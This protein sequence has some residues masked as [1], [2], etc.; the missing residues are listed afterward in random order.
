MT[1]GQISAFLL[2]AR[3]Q[4][5]LFSLPLG[6]RRHVHRLG[7]EAVAAGTG[8]AQELAA[9]LAVHDTMKWASV[10]NLPP[11]RPPQAGTSPHPRRSL[12]VRRTAAD[13]ESCHGW[14]STES[15]AD[16]GIPIVAPDPYQEQALYIS[17]APTLGSQRRPREGG[18]SGVA[19]PTSRRRGAW[20]PGPSATSAVPDVVIPPSGAVLAFAS[21][22]VPPAVAAVPP[23]TP[24]GSH[25]ST[26]AGGRSRPWSEGAEAYILGTLGM[27]P[28][29]RWADVPHL[30]GLAG[31]VRLVAEV[32][33]VVDPALEAVRSVRITL[34]EFHSRVAEVHDIDRMSERWAAAIAANARDWP[35]SLEPSPSMPGYR[36]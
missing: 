34:L 20:A 29:V 27:D 11:Y 7:I 17:P 26:Q 9:L 32:K 14:A 5:S 10:L 15:V 4:G 28:Q 22:G 33:E 25:A 21:P 30:L 2:A 18:L 3:R 1:L 36:P 8:L 35:R 12:R 13:E 6:V 31:T 23:S 16:L 19:R 24:G